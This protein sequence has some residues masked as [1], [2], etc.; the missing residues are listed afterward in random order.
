M[1]EIEDRINKKVEERIRRLE[2]KCT[3]LEQNVA[4]LM[5][6]F[7]R[8][9]NT[10]EKAEERAV[11]TE[12][13]TQR[14]FATQLEVIKNQFQELAKDLVRTMEKNDSMQIDQTDTKKRNVL[15][16]E[17]NLNYQE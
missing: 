6:M 16:R 17:K 13:N 12:Q 5:S 10:F 14:N 9:S 11:I 1:K 7:E 3:N 8:F 15:G 4:Q 2:E